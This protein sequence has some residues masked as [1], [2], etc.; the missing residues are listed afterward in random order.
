[1]NKIIE[2]KQCTIIQHAD[3]LNTSHVDPAVVSSVL[4]DIDAEY[5]RIAKMTTMWGKVHKYLG[6]T[7]DYSLPGKLILSMIDCIGKILDD[8]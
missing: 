6:M 7:I 2:K 3:D 5:G 4:A 8:V 1:M